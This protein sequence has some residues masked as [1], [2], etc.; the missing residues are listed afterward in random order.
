MNVSLYN[1]LLQLYVQNKYKFSP[2]EILSDMKKR[3]IEPNEDTYK[4]IL[5]Y[6]CKNGNME[7]AITIFKY[8]KN[9]NYPL[10]IDIFNL[11]IMGY[12][13]I[14][15]LSN[16]IDVLTIMPK[17]NLIPSNETYTTL[18][19]G[20]AKNND[21]ESIQ[22]LLFRCQKK[23]VNFTNKNILDVIYA[24]IVHK[25]VDYVDEM[26]D[27]LKKPYEA[28]GIDFFGKVI[29]I[30]QED[31]ATKILFYMHPHIRNDFFKNKY[32]NFFINKFIYSNVIPEK[33]IDMCR[34]F[35]TKFNNTQ[36]FT[37]AIYISFKHDN[38]LLTSKLLKEW[39]NN[40]HKLRP[41]YFWPFL[42]KFQNNHDI[43]GLLDYVKDMITIYDVIPCA[44]TIANFIIPNLLSNNIISVFLLEELGIPEEVARNAILYSLLNKNKTKSAFMYVLDYP[45]CYRDFILGSSLRQ[46]LFNT[47]DIYAYLEIARNLYTE[48]SSGKIQKVSLTDKISDIMDFLYENP[49]CISKIMEYLL[50]N[51]LQISNDICE[52]LF[53]YQ[54]KDVL[55]EEVEQ[56]ES[57]FKTLIT[58]EM[59]NE[60][61]QTKDLMSKQLHSFTSRDPT[62]PFKILLH[63]KGWSTAITRD[64][65]IFI[66]DQ[67]LKQ[68]TIEE[69]K[70][71]LK[72]LINEYPTY[73][74]S[75]LS[76]TYAQNLVSV[77]N[78]DDAAEIIEYT[79]KIIKCD[80]N[81]LEKYTKSLLN[82]TALTGNEEVVKRFYDI[83][84]NINY[85]KSQNF[86][87]PFI[88]IHIEQGNIIKA[89]ETAITLGEKYKHI[90]ALK[91]LIESIVLTKDVKLLQHFINVATKIYKEQYILIELILCFL[92]N[93]FLEEAKKVIKFFCTSNYKF[94]V[95]QDSLHNSFE[96]K[97]TTILEKL[98]DF[99]VDYPNA[100]RSIIYECLIEIY[101]EERDYK[102]GLNLR[103]K[104]QKEKVSPTEKFTTYFN[105]LSTN[106]PIHTNL[107]KL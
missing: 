29:D 22:E 100:N 75:Q 84:L 16:A 50:K 79:G 86:L 88:I 93:D 97:Y 98:L 70:K 48:T 57:I 95:I 35:Y 80:G 14:G 20:F 67:L 56:S 9:E 74:S 17:I 76:L 52:T 96:K 5:E 102:N 59:E 87:D 12:F 3:S 36:T 21:I 92:K 31:I 6:Y 40:G 49:T 42:T 45:I 58:T 19:C 28:E 33:I 37:E 63:S 77:G 68:Y 47:Y 91:E 94:T 62:I 104:M 65:N 99:S 55:H 18:M 105:K 82:E 66:A 26:L 72:K 4:K 106:F 25:N 15:E 27:I 11:I 23:K 73:A 69:S 64:M 24:F 78:L 51:K 44:H 46:A 83:F 39:K 53:N 90:P 61:T 13:E 10:D 43:K 81:I 101:V 41:H 54:N 71:I 103:R 85:M 60:Q 107:R 1:M 89:L 2:L 30:K 8:M 7:D 38:D 32:E 34:H